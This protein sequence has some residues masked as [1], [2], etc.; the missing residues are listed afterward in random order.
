[1]VC[2]W[3]PKWTEEGSKSPRTGVTGCSKWLWVLGTKLRFSSRA[4]DFLTVEPSGPKCF[5][6]DCF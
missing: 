1:M 5:H 2:D 6:F 3:C 4:N